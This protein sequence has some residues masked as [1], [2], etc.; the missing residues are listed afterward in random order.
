M[1]R[2]GTREQWED[3][4]RQMWRPA[5]SSEVAGVITRGNTSVTTCFSCSTEEALG[6]PSA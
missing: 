1:G 3:L 6:D 5:E 2:S 4:Y